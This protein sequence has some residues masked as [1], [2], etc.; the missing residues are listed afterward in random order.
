MEMENNNVKK[1]VEV[2]NVLSNEKAEQL[3]SLT[4][5]AAWDYYCAYQQAGI[6]PV[7]VVTVAFWPF[8]ALMYAVK[9]YIDVQKWEESEAKRVKL[10]SLAPLLDTLFQWLEHELLVGTE[11]TKQ[12]KEYV[13]PVC[14]HGS[15]NGPKIHAL[16]MRT[17]RKSV[18]RARRMEFAPLT[19]EEMTASHEIK[20]EEMRTLQNVLLLC[21]DMQ[22]VGRMSQ[23]MTIDA[24][25]QAEPPKILKLIVKGQ[26]LGKTFMVDGDDKKKSTTL[27]T[28]L[29][30]VKLLSRQG[31]L[32]LKF[33]FDAKALNTKV[34][35][36]V[37]RV[38]RKKGRVVYRVY[39]MLEE[40]RQTALLNAIT[41]EMTEKLTGFRQELPSEEVL[42]CKLAI[43]NKQDLATAVRFMMQLFRDIQ[44]GQ[45]AILAKCRDLDKDMR[46]ANEKAVRAA[47]KK[48]FIA[49]SSMAESILMQKGVSAEEAVRL[50]LGVTMEYM[51]K[52]ATRPSSFA[53]VIMEERFMMYIM[54]LYA[55]NYPE[56]MLTRDDLAYCD[57]KDGE[58]VEFVGGVVPGRAIFSL[59]KND[60]PD[61]KYTVR[62]SGNKAYVERPVKEMLEQRISEKYEPDT[63]LLETLPVANQEI[64]DAIVRKIRGG[65]EVTLVRQD[66]ALPAG[67]QY[68]VINVDGEAVACYQAKVKRMVRNEQGELV[69]TKKNGHDDYAVCNT[70]N[71]FYGNKR[72]TVSFAQ[73]LAIPNSQKRIV[74]VVLK[75]TKRV[76]TKPGN[77]KPGNLLSMQI[78][79][80]QEAIKAA[81]NSLQNLAAM[82]SE[83]KETKAAKP[84]LREILA[85]YKKTS[86]PIKRDIA[87]KESATVSSGK[88]SFGGLAALGAE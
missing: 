14:V 4:K 44:D 58:E 67:Y 50:V 73:V 53:G 31:E 32:G 7:G 29:R 72:G 24:T 52:D 25:K 59:E 55:Q 79:Q 15:E 77:T 85:K 9:S 60:I 1:S 18:R 10:E 86:T 82:G 64:A 41:A 30:K 71:A 42:A 49:L 54:S 69:T 61:G 51:S 36:K 38:E 28:A 56:L 62:K 88:I 81:K 11:T 84:S 43:G 17:A 80:K 19:K 6:D 33:D 70:M 26:H 76:F 21:N 23:E 46:S 74:L 45:K 83:K 78:A 63:V 65:K 12:S 13:S 87:E 5:T 57:A 34:N 48:T 8:Q 47:T 68:N 75:D 3:H 20:R 40:L 37:S 35:P 16:C 22:K 39:D 2:I 66:K 27:L